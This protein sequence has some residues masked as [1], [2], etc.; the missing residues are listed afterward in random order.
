MRPGDSVEIELK[1]A[2]SEPVLQAAFEDLAGGP[3]E[4]TRV[5]STYYDTSDG[6]L[7]RRGYTLR[8][9]PRG[10][11]HELTLKQRRAGSL[12]RGEWT[13]LLDEPAVDLALLP[14][15]APR[16]RLGLILPEEFEVRYQTDMNRAKHVLERDGSRIELALDTGV[17]RSELR[18][19]GVAELEFELLEGPVS[20]LLKLADGVL[21]RHALSFSTR[22]KSDRGA[23]LAADTP[24]EWTKATRPTL[25]PQ[26]TIDQAMAKIVAVSVSQT[27][28]NLAAA[29]DGRDSEGVHQLRI[30]LRRLRSALS[31]FRPQ[32]TDRARALDLSA[33]QALKRLGQARDLDVF[34]EETIAPVLQDDPGNPALARLAAIAGEHRQAA[35]DEVRALL[36]DRTFGRFL[37]ALLLAARN[38]GLITQTAG[39]MLKPL[40]IA[41]LARR[42]RKVCKA[43]RRFASLGSERRHEVRIALKKLRYA[44]DFFQ[45]LFPRK[46]TSRYLG[47]MADLQDD[48]GR[49]NDATVA[50]DVVDRLTAGDGDAALGGA[51]VKGW[52]R[53][54]LVTAEPTM[55]EAWRRF[56]EA[57]PFWRD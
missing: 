41:L 5:V 49:L 26:D 16:G 44:C 33:R 56:S 57:P 39:G 38:G 20:G 48:L 42:H 18:E 11:R 12:E 17:I 13:A 35:Y 45:P 22:T 24:P 53:H 32:L 37:V 23:S 47:L 27:I 43:G 46:A 29:A 52:Y 15:D 2:G 34:L 3:P 25:H 19:C 4:P 51:V 6:R 8:L 36:E 31:L 54:R 50:E 9:R 10:A 30:S 40:A 28:G 55:L 1:L 7:W 14:A 21:E